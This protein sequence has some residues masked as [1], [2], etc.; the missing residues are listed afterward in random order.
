MGLFRKERKENDDVVQRLSS[1][2]GHIIAMLKDVFHT[3]QGLDHWKALLYAS[4]LAGF[5]CHQAVKA[6][7]E[8]F[9]VVETNAGRKYFFGDDVNKY[10]MEDKYSVLC[11]MNGI[12]EHV[13][14]GK[15]AP[16]IHGVIKN[17]VSVIGNGDYKIWN[18]YV[19]E[20]VFKEI[21]SC[22]DGIYENMTAKY[23]KNPFEWPILYGI[24]LQNIML[25]A[26]KAVSPENVYIAALECALYISK[27]DVESL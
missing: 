21:K 3:A 10:L 15:A 27:M 25:E 13:C 19:P 2:A 26:M 12:Y 4:G 11:F 23:C 14:P 20:E 7:H 8:S 16:D 18:V 5:A 6:N 17:A 24:V 9:V 1:Q 22:W